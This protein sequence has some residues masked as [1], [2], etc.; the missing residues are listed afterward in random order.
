MQQHIKYTKQLKIK[1]LSPPLGGLGGKKG[2]EDK[3]SRT[4]I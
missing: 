3:N 1:C 4:L 2:L